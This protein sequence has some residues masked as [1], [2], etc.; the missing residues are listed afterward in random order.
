MLSAL[1]YFSNQYCK[2]YEPRSHCFKGG[3]LIRTHFICIHSKGSLEFIWIYAADIISGQHFQNDKNTSL[4]TL[5]FINVVLP[6]ICA[7]TLCKAMFF[8]LEQDT[9]SML[10][11]HS[12]SIYVSLHLMKYMPFSLK[13]MDYPFCSIHHSKSTLCAGALTISSCWYLSTFIL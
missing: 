2:Q 12:S 5:Q 8:V 13:K 3:S 10:L 6:C 4:I 11:S 7:T 9:S 1:M